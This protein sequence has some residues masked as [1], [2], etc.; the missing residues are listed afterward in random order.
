MIKLTWQTEI[1]G[2][3]YPFTQVSRTK[4]HKQSAMTAQ[5]VDVWYSKKKINLIVKLSGRCV[6]TP[7]ERA[8][9]INIA[10]STK[11]VHM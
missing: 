9:V 2:F 6:A 8:S 1:Y 3:Q 10:R 4:E 5:V 11:H 7:R